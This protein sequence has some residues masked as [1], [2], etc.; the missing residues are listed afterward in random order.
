MNEYYIFSDGTQFGP[1]VAH[2]V[3]ASETVTY[4]MWEP[5]SATRQIF[6]DLLIDKVRNM[7]D[8]L[9]IRKYHAG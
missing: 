9:I 1:D 8:E 6:I 5:T 3:P 4:G 7:G 2:G